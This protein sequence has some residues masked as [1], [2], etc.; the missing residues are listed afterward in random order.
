M[1]AGLYI[2]GFGGHGRSVADVALTQGYRQLAFHD[3]A[4]RPDEAFLGFPV[5]DRLIELPPGWSWFPAS[6]DSHR[7]GLQLASDAFA[8]DR[9]GRVRS[10]LSH[11]ATG[12]TIGVATFVG[13]FVH[14]GPRTT[15]GE[16]CILN[17]GAIV[18]H[19]CI[20]GPCSH[21]SVH[22]TVAGSV[23]IGARVFV[24][25]GATVRDGVSIADDVLIGAGSTVVRS[26]DAAGV[27]AGSPARRLGA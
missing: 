5:S 14:V 18:E 17:N 11:V 15:I 10:P 19:D 22:A 25:A 26:I 12:S 7:R 1:S 23:S 24:G 13:H 16:G 2:L 4:A 9:I 3:E 8:R 6:G 20:V 27:Y 21:I